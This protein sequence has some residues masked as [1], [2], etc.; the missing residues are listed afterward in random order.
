MSFQYLILFGKDTLIYWAYKDDRLNS[1]VR[2]SF[3]ACSSYTH[4]N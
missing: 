3:Y 1:F 4:S 2:G